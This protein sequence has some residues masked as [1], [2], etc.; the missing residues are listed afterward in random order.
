MLLIMSATF[1]V[2]TES[3]QCGDLTT[4][5]LVLDYCK[6][7]SECTI[8]NIGDSGI[9]NNIICNCL[10]GYSLPDCSLRKLN[11]SFN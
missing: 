3:K 2:L 6:N 4:S 1:L 11:R 7:G 5:T 10:F 9:N 8:E